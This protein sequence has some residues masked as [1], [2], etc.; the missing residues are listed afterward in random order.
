MR[1]LCFVLTGGDA[2]I[3]PKQDPESKELPSQETLLPPLNTADSNRVGQENK[4]HDVTSCLKKEIKSNSSEKAWTNTQTT[5]DLNAKVIHS[6]DE[7]A[8]KK[9]SSE[10]CPEESDSEVNVMLDSDN[11]NNKDLGSEPTSMKRKSKSV[12]EE[13]SD[14][15]VKR[16]R[17]DKLA[18]SD[19][20]LANTCNKVSTVSPETGNS[21]QNARYDSALVDKV[22]VSDAETNSAEFDKPSPNNDTCADKKLEKV[23]DDAVLKFNS[24]S[25]KEEKTEKGT[26]V[27]DIH[28]TGAK[29]VPDGIQDPLRE[30]EDYHSVGAF[31]TK[32]GRGEK[33][34]SM[35][36]SDKIAKWNVLGCQGA[37]LMHFLERP[38]YFDSVIVGR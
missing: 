33:T 36:C 34:L 30:G 37:L 35:A 20:S 21:D 32:P 14:N 13:S 15:K 22:N 31:R 16:K 27:S 10:L 28:R 2:S 5:E 4:I 8:G 9:N 26:L 3:F 23:I 1:N 17:E 7:S 38:I 24:S 29:C 19:E 12:M 18:E 25:G 6:T 11:L